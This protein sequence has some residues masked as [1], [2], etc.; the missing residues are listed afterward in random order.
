MRPGHPVVRRLRRQQIF[1]EL[2][3]RGRASYEQVVA[4]PRTRDV[5]KMALRL[6]HVREVGA[7]GNCVDPGLR[8]E[9][10][11]VTCHDDHSSELQA[12]REVHRA[13][14]DDSPSRMSGVVKDSEREAGGFD[15]P[16]GAADL[17]F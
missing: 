8:W 1:E 10:I 2:G 11:V 5:E 12:F 4:C 16:S 17:C 7:I 6:I 9:D 15:A 3:A 14:R 13:D